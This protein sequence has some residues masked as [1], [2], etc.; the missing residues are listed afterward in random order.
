M[1]TCLKTH[2]GL[3]VRCFWLAPILCEHDGIFIALRDFW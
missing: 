3:Y 1:H 2:Q